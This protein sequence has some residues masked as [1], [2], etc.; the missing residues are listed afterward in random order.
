MN[1][2]KDFVDRRNQKRLP[3]KEGAFAVLRPQLTKL[4]KIIDI[5]WSGLA[6]GYVV[7]GDENSETSEIDIF[8]SGNGF[9]LEGIPV[10]KI[11]ESRISKKYSMSSPPMKKCSVQFGELNDSQISQM[12]FFIK[13]HT[14]SE[15]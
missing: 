11:S 12:N 9:Y 7:T 5:S 8:L 1:R 15:T 14:K 2:K 13:N 3:V 10:E 6:F 4:G